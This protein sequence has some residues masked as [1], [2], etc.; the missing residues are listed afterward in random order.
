M[1]AL[2]TVPS[3]LFVLQEQAMGSKEGEG[4]STLPVPVE[5]DNE[6]VQNNP[7]QDDRLIPDLATHKASCPRHSSRRALNAL[8]TAA[9][10]PAKMRP[11]PALTTGAMAGGAYAPC[12]VAPVGGC[13]GGRRQSGCGRQCGRR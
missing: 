1:F 6:P 7:V 8:T 13:V 2:S 3:E 10:Q 4:V 11:L 9:V 12:P 5:V